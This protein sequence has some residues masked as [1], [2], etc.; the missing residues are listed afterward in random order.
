MCVLAIAAV[1]ALAS[2]Q[3]QQPT[4]DSTA[5]ALRIRSLKAQIEGLD[6]QIKQEDVKRNKT[7]LGV[8][9]EQLEVMNDRQDSVCLEL[10]SQL[11]DKQL[12]LKE[13]TAKQAAAAL[14]QQI[15]VL[16]Q[17]PSKPNTP[18][19]PNKPARQSRKKK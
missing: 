4:A 10:R 9:P 2:A 15:N 13:L 7:I 14:S 3:N 17:A 16:Q 11:T 1:P 6:K 18:A 12:E 19:K 8:K 5:N